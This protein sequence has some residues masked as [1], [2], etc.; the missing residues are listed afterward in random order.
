MEEPAATAAVAPTAVAAPAELEPDSKKAQGAAA[1]AGA[2]APSKLVELDTEPS[3]SPSR[4]SSADI[5]TGRFGAPPSNSESVA[6]LPAPDSGVE[7]TKRSEMIGWVMYASSIAPYYYL[8]T[9]F[10]PVLLRRLAA[11]AMDEAGFVYFGA[12]PLRPAAWVTTTSTGIAVIQLFTFFFI[13]PLA[14]YGRNRRRIWMTCTTLGGCMSMCILAL[15]RSELWLIGGLMHIFASIC[16]GL[17][18]V[19][20]SAYLPVLTT[21]HPGVISEPDN[22]L[23]K[24][25]LAFA[26]TALSAH[27]S[28]GAFSTTVVMLLFA[29]GLLFTLPEPN[30]A[31][32]AISC[33]VGAW[34]LVLSRVAFHLVGARPG[35]P[36]PPAR[37]MFL[38]IKRRLLRIAFLFRRMPN[39]AITLCVAFFANTGATA[40]TQSSNVFADMVLK[41]S[42]VEIGLL[43]LEFMIFLTAG[44]FSV[45]ILIRTL[46][47][48]AKRVLILVLVIFTLV[49]GYFLVGLS[50][51]ISFGVK[52]AP[53]AFG[54]VA[55]AAFAGGALLPMGRGILASML[56][57][58]LEAEFFGYIG[59]L[60]NIGNLIL[61]SINTSII[62]ATNNLRLTYFGICF[63][64]FVSAIAM[65]FVD[66]E[67][68]VQNAAEVNVE[69]ARHGSLEAAIAHAWHLGRASAGKVAPEPPKDPNAAAAPAPAL[70]DS[71]DEKPA[72][73]AAAVGAPVPVSLAPS[74]AVAVD[75]SSSSFAVLALQEAE[76]PATPVGGGARAP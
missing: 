18:N 53:E 47:I 13:A 6:S 43:T 10:V 46:H 27:G 36:T 44:A 64:F 48:P 71:G 73:A 39:F 25:K 2:D 1:A 45:V 23:R 17:S 22:E 15:S 11:G 74:S 69:I 37:M 8:S 63:C 28:S 72:A 55:I 26:S 32:R 12:I 33:L 52:A 21:S 57:H 5:E 3:G 42:S 49:S 65:C 61:P 38:D 59:V 60:Y 14:D 35:P 31:Y 29:L 24:S 9:S 67:E 70:A 51:S 54:V 19:M 16:W 58:S 34:W 20:Q 4:S 56:P 66:I 41:M 30:D 40:M 50:D 75:I 7:P 62:N 76:A 68:G